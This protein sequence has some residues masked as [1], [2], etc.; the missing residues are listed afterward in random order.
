RKQEARAS[1]LEETH[2]RALEGKENTIQA[3]DAS[4]ASYRGKVEALQKKL[5]AVEIQRL[6][7][8]N[9]FDS[10]IREK[11][12]SDRDELD[13]ATQQQQQSLAGLREEMEEKIQEK[14]RLISDGRQALDREAGE[15]RR[16]SETLNRL[17]ENAD[18]AVAEK[19]AAISSLDAT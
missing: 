14:D 4:I 7:D 3:L 12:Q 17:Q 5:D 19:Q 6:N 15:R 16:L 18:R 9:A 8:L 1:G 13:R 11:E 2:G 10:R